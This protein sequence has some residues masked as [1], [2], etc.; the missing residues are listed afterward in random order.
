M[1]RILNITWKITNKN[2]FLKDFTFFKNYFNI[3]FN[4]NCN[5]RI[6]RRLRW[7]RFLL[8]TG[9]C[10]NLIMLFMQDRIGYEVNLAVF[11]FVYIEHFDPYYNL[12]VGLFF[13][14]SLC[15]HKLIYI[16][17]RGIGLHMNYAAMIEE[18]RNYMTSV[19]IPMRRLHLDNMPS[20]DSV[21]R[22]A[23]FI[24]NL[25]FGIHILNGKMLC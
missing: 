23:V 7:N 20:S 11:N 6:R 3:C 4:R 17:N 10:F 14:F 18:R 12:L 19:G 13:C 1:E 21:K 15:C 24:I 25:F 8:W 22:M 16:R 5:V 2:P 9:A